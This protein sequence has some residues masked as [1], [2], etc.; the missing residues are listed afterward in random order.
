MTDEVT[1]TEGADETAR[2]VVVAKP[3]LTIRGRSRRRLGMRSTRA[4]TL[5]G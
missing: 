2:T 3:P 4:R 1:A 5:D